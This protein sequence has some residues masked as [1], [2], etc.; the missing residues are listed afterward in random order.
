VPNVID[1]FNSLLRRALEKRGSI[2]FTYS[3]VLFKY[4]FLC[5]FN[6]CMVGW[7][8]LT[9]RTIIHV[10]GDSHAKPF[11][12]KAP[13]IVHH[14]SQA[15]AYNLNKDD[16]YSQSKWHLNSFLPRVNKRRDILMLVFG[17]IDARVHIYRQHRKLNCSSSIDDIIEATVDRYGDTI[18]RLRDQGLAVCIHGI[19]PAARK[20]YTSTLPYAGSPEERAY[21]SREFNDKLKRYCCSKDIPY[22]DVQLVTNDGEGFIKDEYAADELHL[23]PVI[24]PFI[25]ERMSEAF[26]GNRFCFRN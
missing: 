6:I 9:G 10:I 11:V 23:N 18:T 21:I 2:Y 24:V 19:P 4:P 14:I 1:R 5:L 7:A 20:N 13:F 12:F 22:V 17:E 16:S 26:G 3:D 8:A 15:T 25:R